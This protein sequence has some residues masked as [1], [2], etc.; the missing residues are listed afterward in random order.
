MECL[1]IFP[2]LWYMSVHH[3]NVN[4]L[5]PRINQGNYFGVNSLEERKQ[6]QLHLL[7]ES[8]LREGKSSQIDKS[9]ATS[10]SFQVSTETKLNFINLS[11]SSTFGRRGT[12]NDRNIHRDQTVYR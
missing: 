1:P 6:A 3:H 10:A 12:F 11:T 8:I 9:T 5:D 7:L 2:P 4:A